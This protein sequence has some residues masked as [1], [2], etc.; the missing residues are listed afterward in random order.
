[1][2]E[3]NEGQSP[4]QDPVGNLVRLAQRHDDVPKE[5][6]AR[7]RETARAEW[8]RLYKRR[9]R[10][11]RI[12]AGFV[13]LAAAAAIILAFWLPQLNNRQQ[14]L[15]ATE[16]QVERIV[17]AGWLVDGELRSSLDG[18]RLFELGQQ[19][20][21]SAGGFVSL[22]SATGQQLRLDER[23]TIRRINDGVLELVAGAVYVDS[24][25]SAQTAN[26]ITP[27]GTIQELGTQYEVRLEDDAVRLRL[28]EGAVRLTTKSG[29]RHEVSDGEEFVL[30]RNGEFSRVAVSSHDPLWGWTT[31]VARVPINSG[32]TVDEFLRWYSREHGLRLVYAGTKLLQLAEETVVEGALNE[33]SPRQALEVV[34]TTSELSAT[35]ADRE[36]VVTPL[37]SSAF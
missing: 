31:R 11:R 15:I 5:R 37:P 7:V 6:A 33:L 24:N 29:V 28:R 26:I 8:Q 35:Q 30:R 18:V 32:A 10:S 14:P 20:E 13:T 2:R 25:E 21:T 34:M 1:M 27:H 19:I 16:W 23:S 12:A 9:Q 4:E 3:H 36:L 22:R 17:G